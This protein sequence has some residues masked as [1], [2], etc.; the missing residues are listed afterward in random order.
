MW[1]DNTYV[2]FIIY[3]H[4]CMDVCKN[5]T[6]F[7]PLSKRFW[8][9]H[10]V[11]TRC[12]KIGACTHLHGS[13]CNNHVSTCRREARIWSTFLATLRYTYVFDELFMR[14]ACSVQDTGEMEG[15]IIERRHDSLHHHLEAH[16]LAS[17]SRDT[18]ACTNTSRHNSSHHRLKAW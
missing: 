5:K 2:L 17:L 10:N 8:L 15:W 6:L 7:M 14:A 9:N 3:Y 13:H 16:C 11:S 4:V 1:H 18:T 12:W